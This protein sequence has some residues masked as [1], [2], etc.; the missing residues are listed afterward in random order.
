MPAVKILSFLKNLNVSLKLC[1]QLSDGRKM[2]GAQRRM[3]KMENW[4]SG[5]PKDAYAA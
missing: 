1:F 4:G 5:E 2:D 3:K